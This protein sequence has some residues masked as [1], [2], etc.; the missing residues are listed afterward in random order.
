MS[1]IQMDLILAVSMQKTLPS[2]NEM[3]I[4]CRYLFKAQKI[5]LARGDFPQVH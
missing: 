1:L 4:S 3:F 2:L 5:F